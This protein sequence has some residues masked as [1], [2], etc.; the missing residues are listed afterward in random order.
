MWST[1]IPVPRAIKPCDN[2]LTIRIRYAVIT[3][4][5]A[6]DSSL[7]RR[8]LGTSIQIVRMYG[9]AANLYIACMTSVS[10]IGIVTNCLLMAA[11]RARSDL[12]SN[13]ERI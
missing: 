12:T 6:F 5:G 3:F 11:I 7:A 10:G 4:S 8:S 2:L 9:L 13:I 1:N